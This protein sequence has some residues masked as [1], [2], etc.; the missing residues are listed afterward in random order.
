M[1]TS[2]MTKDLFRHFFGVPIVLRDFLYQFDVL[3][4]ES[5]DD[6]GGPTFEVF[7]KEVSFGVVK[8]LEEA[9][10]IVWNRCQAALTIEGNEDGTAT[11]QV[12][13]TLPAPPM[14]PSDDVNVTPN[15]E[16]ADPFE[17][18]LAYKAQ[19][20]DFVMGAGAEERTPR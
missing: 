18:D 9:K 17:V 14:T 20:H 1:T 8:S 11:T 16:C 15:I 10:E 6:D 2:T 7:Q 12:A 19:D 4:R 5:V 3:I 13:S